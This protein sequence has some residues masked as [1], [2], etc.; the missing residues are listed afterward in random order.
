LALW[1]DGGREFSNYRLPP[2]VLLLASQSRLLA[3]FRHF[4]ATTNFAGQLIGNFH[5]TGHGFN[6]SGLRIRPQR[7]L[8]TL[9]FENATASTQVAKERRP[10]HPT[11][12][13]DWIASEGAPRSPSSRRSSE[14]GQWLRL[15][16][17]SIP[18]PCALGRWRR[19]LG[20][21]GNEPIAIALDHGCEF[22]FHCVNPL[23]FGGELRPRMSLT[24]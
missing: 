11:V 8:A 3:N 24:A 20:A 17:T 5:M 1:G 10:L 12:T 23:V 18:Q 4:K 9:A 6:P 22:V 14:S 7:M 21:I 19:N 13:V 15:G 16:W 2:P